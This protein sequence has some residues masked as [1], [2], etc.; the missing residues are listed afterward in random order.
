MIDRL[1]RLVAGIEHLAA[2]VLHSGRSV[3][4]A[5]GQGLWVL[6]R[7]SHA[8]SD[9]FS[10]VQERSACGRAPMLNQRVQA[11]HGGLQ[12]PFRRA[13]EQSAP[14]TMRSAAAQAVQRCPGAPRPTAP[15][16]RCPTALAGPWGTAPTRRQPQQPRRRGASAAAAAAAS[17][18][19]G[20]GGEAG[21]ESAEAAFAAVQSCMELFLLRQA[22]ADLDAI[23]NYL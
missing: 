10:K 22:S 8:A 15:A 5:A 19:G 2:Q 21:S 6:Q 17:G 23:I 11:G 9:Q 3:A 16:P 14:A 20:G 13:I 4:G 1:R 7:R 12:T 18:G